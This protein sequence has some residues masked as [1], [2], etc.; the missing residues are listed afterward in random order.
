[1]FLSA[2]CLIG[3]DA[4]GVDVCEAESATAPPSQWGKF[5]EINS[6]F[7]SQKI[8]RANSCKHHESYHSPF[9]H[10]RNSCP[11][12]GSVKADISG[13]R[14]FHLE[15]NMSLDSDNFFIE[16]ERNVPVKIQPVFFK[17]Q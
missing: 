7:S 9:R 8:K 6:I 17:R 10:G 16:L 13:S 1:M 14:I 2:N 4:E 15:L 3:C 11:W 12:C 5:I